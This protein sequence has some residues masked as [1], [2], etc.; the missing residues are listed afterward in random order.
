MPMKSMRALRLG[1]CSMTQPSLLDIPEPVSA[2]ESSYYDTAPTEEMIRLKSAK[3]RMLAYLEAH[4]AATNVTL[5]RPDV[6]GLG[7][8]GRLWELRKS[9]YIITDERV[10]GGLWLYRLIGR[11]QP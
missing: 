6:A 5:S 1:W 2:P 9:G 10:K 3:L 8:S 11:K 7:Y 4:G